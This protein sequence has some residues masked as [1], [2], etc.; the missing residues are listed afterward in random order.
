MSDTMMA[1]HN[2]YMRRP[3]DQ[4][5]DSVASL[6]AVAAQDKQLSRQVS[7]N[8]KDL[9][10]VEAMTDTSTLAPAANGFTVFPNAGTTVRLQSPKGTAAFTHWSFGQICRMLGAPASY[11]RT[12]PPSH[13]AADLTYGLQH[14][15]VGTS[16]N[17]LVRM[18]N[19]GTPEPIARSINSDSYGR[20]WD[21]EL[22][23]ALQRQ[24]VEQP[25]RDG[26]WTLPPTWTGEAAGAYRG[27]R[28][29][30]VVLVNGGSI[31]TDPSLRNAG[32]SI[33]SGN[34]ANSSRSNQDTMY[35]GLLIRNSEVGAC[36]V[37]I[38]R[39]LYRY[40]CGNHMIW[41]AVIDKQFRR[42]HVGSHVLRD[43][44][45]EI[46]DVAWK[47]T[48]RSES[49]DTA[50]IKSL[51]D[52]EIAHTKEAVIDELRKIGAT[53]EQAE[54]AYA[55]CEATEAV[56]PRSFWGVAQGLTRISQE[57]GYEDERYQL[58]QLATKVLTRGA[59]LVAA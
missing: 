55:R 9:R 30:F 16:A 21:A 40:I 28:D 31:V 13:I 5:Y 25:G 58:D 39:I 59:R 8:L 1:A 6:V 57:E 24:L 17:V 50:I 7:Y 36:S 2:E 54:Q 14:S 51:I 44:V 38:E 33:V 43:V 27:D 22:F 10:V 56:S 19:G 45:R 52:H 20:L 46:A 3:K 53:K 49:S 15:P 29:S 37:V 42:R 23:S 41:G 11:L 4:R 34:D 47:W 26:A 12:L 48:S 32:P 35:R 18:P